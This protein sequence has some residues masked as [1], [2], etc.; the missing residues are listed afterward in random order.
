MRVVLIS[1]PFFKE[2]HSLENFAK[3]LIQINNYA[4]T[5]VEIYK[6]S[7]RFSFYDIYKL[8]SMKADIYHIT[9]D[10]HYIG[11]FLPSRKVIHTIHDIGHYLEMPNLLKKII[12]RFIWFEWP[13]KFSRKILFDS[14]ITK[15]RVINTFLFKPQSSAVILLSSP[16][17]ISENRT[18]PK[19]SKL[20]K[21]LQIG[22][23]RNK[24]L[25]NLLKAVTKLDFVE[26]IVV[27]KIGLYD[28][29]LITQY[30]ISVKN[31]V[32]ISE[33]ELKNL[34][35]ESD[36]LFFGSKHEGFGLPI[37][38]AQSA[39]L[40]VI[41]SNFEPMTE[42]A[43]KGALYV[44][45]YNI[46]D[47]RRKLNIIHTN[48]SLRKELIDAGLENIKLLSQDAMLKKYFKVY[49]EVYEESSSNRRSIS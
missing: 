38:E 34:Y 43:N 39:H 35:L 22:T 24:N 36:V 13:I 5:S 25:T 26:L 20:L 40:P 12:Y 45:P 49:N 19:A 42:V 32:N 31:F 47:I 16:L 29:S 9:G 21:V 33:E 11:P 1:R 30:N 2:A 15:K 17:S 28:Q 44:D 18:T 7:R 23:K 37:L 14:S 4:T 48:L 10:V 3:L 8:R 27:G 46:G 41:T 6:L